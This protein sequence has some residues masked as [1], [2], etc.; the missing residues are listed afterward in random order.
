MQEQLNKSQCNAEEIERLNTKLEMEQQ[1]KQAAIR[2]LEEVVSKKDFSA[3]GKSKNKASS[4][5]LKKKEKDCR[6]LQLELTL[7]KEKYSQ[8][9]DK[10]Q[11]EV[12]D[13]Q[14]R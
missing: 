3:S 9:S 12:Q 8:L 6:K 5:D 14:V 7:E 13:L 10:L 1:R 2:K 11:K 4:V